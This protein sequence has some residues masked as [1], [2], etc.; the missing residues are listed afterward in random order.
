MQI[1]TLLALPIIFY[2][3]E[4]HKNNQKN[5]KISE[6]KLQKLKDRVDIHIRIKYLIYPIIMLIMYI[7]KQYI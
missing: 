6:K 7:L 1:T 4:F 3:K 2:I 5:K